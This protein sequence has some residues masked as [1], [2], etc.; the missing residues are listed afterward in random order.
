MPDNDYGISEKNAIKVGGLSETGPKSERYYLNM[1]RGPKGEKVNYRRLGSCCHFESPNSPFAMLDM[2]EII[3]KG[4]NKPVIIYLNMYDVP[5][6]KLIAP[7]GF[8]ISNKK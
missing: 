8:K 3:Y 2:Y 1:L 4:I 5:N 6:G 7:V